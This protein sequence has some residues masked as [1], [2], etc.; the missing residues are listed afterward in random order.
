MTNGEVG[1]KD[2]GFELGLTKMRV[3]QIE[4]EA[5]EKLKQALEKEGITKEL[6][7][8]YF[9][10]LYN[11]ENGFESFFCGALKKFKNKLTGER[12]KILLDCEIV[13]W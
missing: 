6:V 12:E 3:C 13:E 4:K 7:D 5:K 10:D 2:I 11:K 9:H 8:D 1:Q